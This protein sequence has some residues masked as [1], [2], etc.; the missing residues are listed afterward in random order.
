MRPEHRSGHCKDLGIA[1]PGPDGRS[2]APKEL[3]AVLE[4]TIIRLIWACLTPS[5]GQLLTRPQLF[6]AALFATLE[7]PLC[8]AFLPRL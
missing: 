1:I 6:L 8:L 7:R 5:L 2:A 3:R 4:P